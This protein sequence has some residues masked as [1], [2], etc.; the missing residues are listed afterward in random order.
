M[1]LL[2][3]PRRHSSE[4]FI[5]PLG[6]IPCNIDFLSFFFLEM[7]IILLLSCVTR[8]VTAV[9]VSELTFSFLP[10]VYSLN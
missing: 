10:S 8:M 2:S 4:A 3:A 5:D 6:R 9:P 7:I 1:N